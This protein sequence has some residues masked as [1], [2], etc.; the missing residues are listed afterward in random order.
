MTAV[1]AWSVAALPKDVIPVC[2]CHE[3]QRQMDKAKKVHRG[4]RFCET[5]YARLFKRSICPGCG[6]FAR[7]P[8]FDDAAVCR[9]C[10]VKQPCVRCQRSGLK[11][12]KLTA[13][14][15][16]CVSCAHYFRAPEPCERCTAPSTRLVMT[17]VG[18]QKLRCCPACLSQ[19][20]TSCCSACRRPRVIVSKEGPALCKKCFERGEVTCQ[21]CEKPMAAGY[22]KTCPACFWLSS[23]EARQAKLLESMDNT[24]ARGAMA[25]FTRWL[26]DRRGAHFAALNMQRYQPFLESIYRQWA[27]VPAYAELV[28]HYGAQ[29]LRRSLS[30]VKWLVDESLL[31]VDTDLRDQSSEQRRVQQTLQFFPEGIA[32]EALHRYFDEMRSRGVTWRTIRL[33]L[34]SARRLLGHCDASGQKLAD[35]EGFKQFLAKRPGLH[36]SLYGFVN[37]LNRQYACSL[38]PRVDVQWLARAAHRAR[39]RNLTS[40]Y[41]VVL[42][43]EANVPRWIR[44]AMAYFHGLKLLPKMLAYREQAEGAQSGF[45]VTHAGAEFWVPDPRASCSSSLPLP[46]TV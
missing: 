34:G 38:D 43:G 11:I 29:N 28:S 31:V 37:F 14:G 26:R 15:P 40:E 13:Q 9:A 3:C 8:K 6:N 19:L 16:A 17:P 30:V 46:E 25:R 24:D 36:C 1:D 33:A 23:F 10:E 39:E 41:V 44:A 21:S 20:T 32:G 22:G 18:D 7:L 4:K 5:C 42:N 35:Q 27:G 45:M 12:G 2:T